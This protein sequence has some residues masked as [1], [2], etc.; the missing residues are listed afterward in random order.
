M[1][2][3]DI[4]KKIDKV[5]FFLKNKD[6]IEQHY[7]QLNEAMYHNQAQSIIRLSKIITRY[8]MGRV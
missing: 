6:K 4:Q 7:M 3:D 1:N 8:H 5:D 2:Q